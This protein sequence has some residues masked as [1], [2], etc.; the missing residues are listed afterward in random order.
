MVSNNIKHILYT[1]NR[2]S[3]S[4]N[5]K[6]GYGTLPNIERYVGNELERLLTTDQNA[7]DVIASYILGTKSEDDLYRYLMDAIP[8]YSTSTGSDYVERYV[9]HLFDK[10]GG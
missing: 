6:H 10:I 3:I 4:S 9:S 2:D 5:T 7:R 8:R 1:V